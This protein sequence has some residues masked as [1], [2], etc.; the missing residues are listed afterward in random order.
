MKVKKEKI[1]NKI[2]TLL[3]S[4]G[5]CSED[6]IE[7]FYPCVRDR[8]D[9]SVMKCR[10]SGVIFLSRC[11]HVN[12]SRYN[13]QSGFNYWLAK[14]RAQVLSDTLEDNKRRFEQF[15]DI[16]CG[17]KML[18][19]GTGGG[20]ILEFFSLVAAEVIAIEPQKEA[21]N[22]LIECGY[23]VSADIEDITDSDFDIVT[24]FHVFEHLAEPVETLK[25]IFKIMKKGAKLI[26]EVPHANDFLISFLE[27]ESFKAFTFW[28]EHLI[29]HT[30]ESLKAFLKAA[31]FNKIDI[32]GYQRYP[33]ANHLYWLTKGNPGGHKIWKILRDPELES[34]YF[35]MLDSLNKTDTLIALA[36]K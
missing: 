33:L 36:E 27:L 26:V 13:T 32:C 35:K 10:N 7:C 18:D 30:R 5:V 14:D 31:G 22:S 2:Q 28:S 23:K 20:G 29:L 24:L 6:S 1:E 19:V 4:L 16:I 21:R 11:N 17:K 34:C 12:I 9:I 8:N 3:Y 15:K 25:K